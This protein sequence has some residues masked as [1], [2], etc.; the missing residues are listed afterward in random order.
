M[1]GGGVGII[2][3]TGLPRKSLTE[4]ATFEKEP[5]EQ[6]VPMSMRRAFK[7]MGERDWEDLKARLVWS[8]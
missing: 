3:V 8:I 1:P 7:L 4:E 6:V 5:R 2:L